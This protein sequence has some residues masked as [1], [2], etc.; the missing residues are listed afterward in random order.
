MF[1][2]TMRTG[3]HE[4]KGRPLLPPMPY[5][6]VG[7]LDR[8]GHQGAVRLPAVAPAGEEPG[9]RADR[10]AG[11]RSSNDPP[12]R[13]RGVARAAADG[14]PSAAAALAAA[15]RLQRSGAAA[16]PGRDGTLRRRRHQ[17]R[18][19]RRQP[20]VLAAVPAVD[21]RRRQ[22]RAGSTC[23]PAPPSTPATRASGSSP[24]ARASGRS[25]RSAAAR[26][27][28][29][30]CGRRRDAGCSPAATCG[31]RSGTDAVLAPSDG[32]AGVVEVAPG[33]AAQH[34]V[35]QRLR[36]LPRRG[37]AA[38]SG[39]TPLQLSD[40]SRSERDPRRAA[41]AGDGDAADAVR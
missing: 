11:G 1:I 24:S 36:G 29:G 2:A 38:R 37:A 8:R 10:S 6:M 39:S 28:R 7:A 20:P 14:C 34:P 25:S 35:A 15:A 18:S 22:A 32:V 5:P 23:R 27:R 16:A 41:D 33:T 21:R 30:C 9:A 13:V 31:T 3:R 12:A 17:G 26:S 40:R 19:T 4:G